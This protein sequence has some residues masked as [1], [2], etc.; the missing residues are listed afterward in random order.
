MK[1]LPATGFI[2]TRELLGDQSAEVPLPA[3]VPVSRTTLWRWMRAGN[4][5]AP[6]KIGPRAIAFR[7]EDVR[8]WIE[9]QARAAA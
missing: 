9:Q 4:F 8:A 1:Q 2:R 6:V 5:P 7:A 3:I